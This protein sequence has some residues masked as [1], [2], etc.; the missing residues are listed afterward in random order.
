[1][2]GPNLIAAPKDGWDKS[3]HEWQQRSEVFEKLVEKFTVRGDLVADPFAGSGTT[4]RA[5]LTLSRRVWGSD[6]DAGET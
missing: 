2:W 3:L 5:A 1:M 6:I 4:L